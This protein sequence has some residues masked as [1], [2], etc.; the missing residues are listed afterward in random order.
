VKREKRDS[1]G[2]DMSELED[3]LAKRYD[4]WAVHNKD[5]SLKDV[6]PQLTDSGDWVR[7]KDV[8]HLIK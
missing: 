1:G 7:F 3:G 2:Q 8:W 4:W 6:V 5:G